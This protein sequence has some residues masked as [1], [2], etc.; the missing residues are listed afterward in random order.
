MQIRVHPTYG[1]MMNLKLT[2]KIIQH[3]NQIIDVLNDLFY[4]VS[5]G[6][7]MTLVLLQLPSGGVSIL[8][9][10]VL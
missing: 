9:V 4:A 7:Y 3:S 10:N 8:L 5:I 6:L 1:C 2:N